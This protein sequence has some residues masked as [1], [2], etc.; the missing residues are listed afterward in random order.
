MVHLDRRGVRSDRSRRGRHA[1]NTQRYNMARHAANTQRVTEDAHVS[2]KASAVRA[3]R[4][5]LKHTVDMVQRSACGM[6]RT[7]CNV[8][9]AIER[10]RVGRIWGTSDRSA[11]S[12]WR[13]RVREHADRAVRMACNNAPAPSYVAP[14]RP[15]PAGWPVHESDL[16]FLSQ[17]RTRRLGQLFVRVASDMQHTT[18]NV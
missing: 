16:Q 6:R 9:H 13:A 7:A 17:R 5:K 15:H 12:P 10:E 11:L 14:A 2:C 1:A 18:C 3:A 8:Q 4:C